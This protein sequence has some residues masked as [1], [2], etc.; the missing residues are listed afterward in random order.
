LPVLNKYLYTPI[1]RTEIK[2]QSNGTAPGG[3]IYVVRRYSNTGTIAK[4]LQQY[5]ILSMQLPIQ[6]NLP[7]NWQSSYMYPCQQTDPSCQVALWSGTRLL[8]DK[9][10]PGIR[11][12][13]N[14]QYLQRNTRIV[15]HD[16]LE[17]TYYTNARSNKSTRTTPSSR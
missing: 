13:H 14:P 8:L 1:Q 4:P 7:T 2:E 10:R 3:N 17:H 9:T 12:N 5:N 11:P 16:S 6:P 15:Q